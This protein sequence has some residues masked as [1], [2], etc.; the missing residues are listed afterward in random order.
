ME[1]KVRQNVKPEIKINAPK[2]SVQPKPV[3]T[4][5]VQPK[6]VQPAPSCEY[7]RQDACI[8]TLAEHEYPKMVKKE[9]KSIEQVLRD[10][11]AIRVNSSITACP[12]AGKYDRNARE[13]TDLQ[14]DLYQSVNALL[15]TAW[16]MLKAGQRVGEWS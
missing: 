5:P 11:Q 15:Y 7:V 10:I 13:R 14:E 3:Q 16:N 1:I 2:E 6:S 8:P 9:M 4:Q 12:R